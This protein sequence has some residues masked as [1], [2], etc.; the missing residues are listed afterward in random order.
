MRKVIVA[1]H[2]GLSKGLLS[3]LS[4]LAGQNVA[5]KVV[6]YSLNP[7]E[8][9][10]D[11][12]AEIE[13]EMDSNFDYVILTDILGGSVDN[14]LSKLLIHD[15]VWLISGANLLML[16]EIVLSDQSNTDDLCRTVV[17]NAKNGINLRN[18]I[19][20]KLNEEEDF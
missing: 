13:K 2:G 11:F 3:T 19:I 20:A 7:S 17:E 12:A 1:S 8:D 18:G 10:N 5:E 6:T 15:N 16:L 14:A 9:A 4:M